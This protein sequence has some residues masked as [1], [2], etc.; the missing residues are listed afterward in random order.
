MKSHITN[1]HKQKRKK[2]LEYFSADY[3]NRRPGAKK[4][5]V[6][7]HPEPE[8]AAIWDVCAFF[9]RR[10]NDLCSYDVTLQSA[11]IQICSPQKSSCCRLF[12]NHLTSLVFSTGV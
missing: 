2:N 6:V 10:R 9:H 11:D 4:H 7:P 5:I 1:L 8:L 12:L 3:T